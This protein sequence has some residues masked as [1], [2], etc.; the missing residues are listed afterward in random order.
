MK[1]GA[2]RDGKLVFIQSKV[3]H[4]T[5]A[6][7][8]TGVNITMAATHT[9]GVY[10][11][12]YSFC[13]GFTVYTN[14]PPVGAFR[15]YGYQYAHFAIERL[16]DMLSRKLDMDIFEL[17]EKNYLNKNRSF[18]TGE[19]VTE[20]YGD[21]K[22]CS[23]AI[24]SIIYDKEKVKED[25][26]Y[27]YGRGFAAVVKTPKGA[28]HSSKG[29][30]VKFNGDGS[31]SVNMGGAEVGQGLRTVVQQIAAEIL[32]ISP[33]KFVFTQKLILNIHR[34]SGKQLVRCLL[35]KVGEQ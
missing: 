18:A 2:K 11:F 32:K 8:D 14:T 15:G 13:E 4:S 16:M 6:Y 12:P 17:R 20:D 9:V 28:P 30:Y 33:K 35:Y 1:I 10:E 31:V 23:D 34:G 25:E 29:C 21:I 3:Y 27:F 24:K 7:A 19:V 22:K 26:N 5:G